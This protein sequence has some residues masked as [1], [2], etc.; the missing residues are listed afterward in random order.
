[1]TK[2]TSP[3][4]FT[5]LVAREYL[6]SKKEA[7]ESK[8]L[9]VEEIQFDYSTDNEDRTHILVVA[10]PEACDEECFLIALKAYLR[11]QSENLKRHY[12]KINHN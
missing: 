12:D 7:D 2:I 3:V 5:D 4:V 8:E 6:M 9:I 1:M 10:F 11:A